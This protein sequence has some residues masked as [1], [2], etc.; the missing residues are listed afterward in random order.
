MFALRRIGLT[1]SLSL[2]QLTRGHIIKLFR[3]TQKMHQK[4]IKGS[5]KQFKQK[6]VPFLLKSVFTG[7]AKGHSLFSFL[8]KHYDISIHILMYINYYAR[9]FK[10]TLFFADLR[11]KCS[12]EYSLI[13]EKS[14]IPFSNVKRHH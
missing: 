14:F 5:G 10:Y 13:I 12:Y 7:I 1:A 3:G 9:H 2:V 4:W 11:L 6:R 8:L